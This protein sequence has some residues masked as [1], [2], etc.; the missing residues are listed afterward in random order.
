MKVHS[1]FSTPKR[2]PATS[3]TTMTQIIRHWRGGLG[4]RCASL[5]RPGNLPSC[6]AARPTAVARVLARCS[7][8][9]ASSHSLCWSRM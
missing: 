1:C 2:M 9:V 5:S 4:T 7:S 6:S 3:E 8:A